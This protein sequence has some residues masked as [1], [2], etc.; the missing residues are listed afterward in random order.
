MIIYFA[1]DG[2]GDSSV[3]AR[4]YIYILFKNINKV[5]SYF[6]EKEGWNFIS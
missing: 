4:D 5:L 2:R 3:S 6:N 1:G